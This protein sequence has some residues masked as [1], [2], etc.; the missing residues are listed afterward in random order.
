MA[1][2]HLIELI[3][4]VLNE[5]NSQII[6]TTHSPYVLSIINNL[7]FATRVAQKNGAGI[8]AVNTVLPE[9]CW[10]N[11]DTTNVYFLNNGYCH[12]VFD[13]ETGLIDQNSL[14]GISEELGAD[15]EE[16]YDIYARPYHE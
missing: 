10:L 14:D 6:I 15:F 11:P 2:K 3:A 13:E 7:L 12:S 4:I 16:L 5:S 8:N 1:Q 9:A